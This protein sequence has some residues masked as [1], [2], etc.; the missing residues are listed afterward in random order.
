MSGPTRHG[1]RAARHDRLRLEL[2]R[3]RRIGL[4]RGE[5]I[6]N[7]VFL[8]LPLATLL[9]MVVVIETVG[10]LKQS[11]LTAEMSA[12]S[13]RPVRFGR[14]AGSAF[15]YGSSRRFVVE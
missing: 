13:D 14:H 3:A 15:W 12:S 1:R 6:V 11:G 2:D 7:P 4:R 9:F 10:C 8:G 5:L